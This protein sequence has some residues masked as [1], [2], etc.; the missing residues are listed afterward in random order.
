MRFHDRVILA[1]LAL[2]AVALLASLYFDAWIAPVAIGG[3]AIGGVLSS[4]LAS[5]EP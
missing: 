2:W 5:R 4:A 1:Y 3:G